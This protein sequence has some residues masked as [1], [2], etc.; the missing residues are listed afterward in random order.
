MP[1]PWHKA[2]PAH[3][4]IGV[5]PKNA[6]LINM[7]ELYPKPGEIPI[8]MA[9]PQNLR[10]YQ[11]AAAAN[12]G[13]EHF[14]QR[15]FMIHPGFLNR[16]HL[17]NGNRP[18]YM[19]APSSH[20]VNN[21]VQ[22]QPSTSTANM[23]PYHGYGAGILPSPNMNS[24]Q[25]HNGMMNGMDNKNGVDMSAGQRPGLVPSMPASSGT[26]VTISTASPAAQPTPSVA[27]SQHSCTSC[28]CPG[29]SNPATYPYQ[30]PQMPPQNL[31]HAPFS[32]GLLPIHLQHAFLPHHPFAPNGLNQDVM[33]PTPYGLSQLAQPGVANGIPNLVYGYNLANLYQNA[34]NSRKPKKMTNCHN[35]G[36]SKHAAQDCTENSM[37][38]M[39][40]QY[41]T[42]KKNSVTQNSALFTIKFEQIGIT[43][44]KVKY[45]E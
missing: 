12:P 43:I 6:S 31:W 11:M 3:T 2:Q 13:L 1:G 16:P 14:A 4:T 21:S 32:N 18:M 33:F 24:A 39:S 5:R 8:P 10:D 26:T 36:S 34:A 29:H 25:Q 15:Q 28:G 40:G 44:I 19:S 35:C 38:T 22:T 45:L 9:I 41:D 27:T 30:V 23:S 20:N 7:P 17:M 37:E 42:V